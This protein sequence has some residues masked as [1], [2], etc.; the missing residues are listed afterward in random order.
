[1][2]P[3]AAKEV[4]SEVLQI[5]KSIEIVLDRTIDALVGSNPM[6]EEDLKG[7]L[8]PKPYILEHGRL[9]D[10][11]D[12]LQEILVTQMPDGEVLK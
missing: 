10:L 3:E 9:R 1:M 7:Y 11:Q 12:A 8:N 2:T 6:M 5:V 4:R